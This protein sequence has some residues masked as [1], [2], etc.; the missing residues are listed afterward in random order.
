MF[1]IVHYPELSST[2]KCFTFETTTIK[3]R[4]NKK[5]KVFIKKMYFMYFFANADFIV[6]DLNEFEDVSILIYSIAK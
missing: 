6:H 2:P 3:N 5:I 4:S 1:S